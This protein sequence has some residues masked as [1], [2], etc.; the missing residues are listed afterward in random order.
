[1]THRLVP[2]G[3]LSARSSHFGTAARTKLAAVTAA[4]AW[5]EGWLHGLGQVD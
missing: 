3:N 5:A 2:P 4:H 1:M